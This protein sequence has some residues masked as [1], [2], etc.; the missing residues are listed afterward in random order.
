MPFCFSTNFFQ[1]ISSIDG[2][3]VPKEG[4]VVSYKTHLIPPKNEKMQAVH[5]EIVQPAEGVKHETWDSD[6]L[7]T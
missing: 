6:A 3:Y 2:D 4:D 5:V 7:R 1:W